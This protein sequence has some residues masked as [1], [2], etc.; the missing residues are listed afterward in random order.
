MKLIIKRDQ[1]AMKGMLGGHKGMQFTLSYRLDLTQDEAQLV[2]H[3]KLG[4]Y[5]LTWRSVQGTQVPGETIS[6]LV[7]GRSVTL[8]DVTTLVR[9]ED[10]IKGACDELPPLFTVVRTFGGEEVVEYPRT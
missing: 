10:V 8:S 2:E 1:Q 4:E 5:P 9:N 7:A 6:S 3:Y